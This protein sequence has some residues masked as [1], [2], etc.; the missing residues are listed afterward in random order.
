MNSLAR[1][2]VPFLVGLALS[3]AVVSA[4]LPDLVAERLP[5]K[6]IAGSEL[7]TKRASGK[8]T[9]RGR[10]QFSS[11]AKEY[12]VRGGSELAGSDYYLAFVPE[13]TTRVLYVRTGSQ[14]V[15]SL[16]SYGTEEAEISGIARTLSASKLAIISG[17]VPPSIASGNSVPAFPKPAPGATL[18]QATMFAAQAYLA[19]LSQAP[20]EKAEAIPGFFLDLNYESGMLGTIALLVFFGALGLCCAILAFLGFKQK[21]STPKA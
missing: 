6:R 7:E 2:R 20:S 18:T 19:Y 10:F 11:I 9:V 1:F 12:G 14:P 4:T 3:A 8:I 13:G 5:A 17:I 21:A 15:Y 16:L